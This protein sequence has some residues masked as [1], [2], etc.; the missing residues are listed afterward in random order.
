[1][2]HHPSGVIPYPSG[3]AC[4][5]INATW[6]DALS[7]LSLPGPVTCVVTSPPY[8]IG[9]RMRAGAGSLEDRLSETAYVSWLLK[10][11]DRCSKVLAPGGSIFLN[12][13]FKPAAPE[14]PIMVAARAIEAIRA[15]RLGLHLVNV[16]S[17][18]HSIVTPD[19]ARGHFTPLQWDTFLNQS[20]EYVFHFSNVLRP[21]MD[22]KAIGVPHQDPRNAARFG[23]GWRCRGNV[24][25]VPYATVVRKTP[26]RAIFPV[27]LA[28]LCIRFSGISEK[29]I[30]LDPFAGSGTTGVAALKARVPRTVLIE[31]DATSY[32]ESINRIK[33]EVFKCH[34]T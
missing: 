26:H 5:V 34:Q 13:G 9:K 4:T 11:L 10:F 7:P 18:V 2:P 29:T 6:E 15:G 1:M 24:W 32:A 8:N 12:I 23:K 25:F 3:G 31:K 20:W 17:W 30:V 27:G 19:G 16:I 21:K 22:R 14:T 28:D 33:N